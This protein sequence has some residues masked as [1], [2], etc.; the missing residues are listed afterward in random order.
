MG[1][2]WKTRDTKLGRE[3]AIKSLPEAFAS[4]SDRLARLERE[5]RMLATLN[6][7][8][9]AH[10]YG[11][12]ESDG[13][14]F[15]VMELVAGETLADRLRRG[16]IPVEEALKLGLQIAEALEAA[17]EKG[18][19]HRDLKPANIKVTPGGQVKVLDF[20]LAKAFIGNDSRNES[21]LDLSNSPT[22]SIAA[23]RQ[24]IILGTAAYMSPEQAKSRQLDKR[25][26]IWSFG[27]VLMEMLTGRATFSGDDVTDILAS[28]L[29]ADPDW[30][31]LPANLNPRLREV[32]DRCLEKDV[33]KRFRD[34]GDVRIDLQ[35]V[36]A[37]PTGSLAGALGKSPRSWVRTTILSAAVVVL[38]IVVTGFAAWRLKPPDP[39][40]VMNFIDVLPEDQ[41]QVIR[42]AQGLQNASIIDI[43]RDGSR[44]VYSTGTQIYIRN[45]NEMEP[46]P[47]QGASGNA[48]FAPI[49]SSD[50]QWL[51][52]ASVG[53]PISFKRIPVTGGTPATIVDGLKWPPF[54]VSSDVNE[55]LLFSQ[56]EGIMEVPSNGGKPRLVIPAAAGERLASP[57]RLPDGKSIL[58][59]V[60][61]NTGV[62]GWDSGQIQVYSPGTGS[63][64]TVWMAGNA[65]RYVPSGHI[66]FAQG[67]T[68]FA[69]PFDL[70][71]L[72]VTGGQVAMVEAVFR[73][74]LGNSDAT[75]YAISNTGSLVYFPGNPAVTDGNRALVWVDLKGKVTSIP[76]APLRAYT[77]ARISPDHRKVAL[78]INN[79][80]QNDIWT[81]DL[82]SHVL[83]QLTF[84][85]AN[86]MYPL[87]SRDG[88]RIFFYSAKKPSGVYSIPSQGGDAT[89]I[90]GSDTL[91]LFPASLHKD[92]RTI[93]VIVASG[94]TSIDVS[95]LT[96][97]GNGKFE[98]LLAED[99]IENEPDFAPNGNFMV[100]TENLDGRNSITVR[101]Y[102]D[103]HKYRIIVDNG[104]GP[105]FS[106]DGSEIFYFNGSGISAA[107]IEYGSGIRIMTGQ[108]LFAGSYWYGVAGPSGGQGRAWDPDP[109]GKRFLMI[110]IPAA[111]NAKPDL[112]GR[113][114]NIT[115]NWFQALKA[116]LP[117]P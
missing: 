94:A 7:P 77:M 70:S 33:N 95:T 5:A 55:M 80:N 45:L 101:P 13:T 50:G 35:K 84:D 46:R 79:G 67:G 27:C 69:V 40:P 115:L 85:A 106:G 25:T 110:K 41:A 12:E 86:E 61:T 116:K 83:T 39:H 37:D 11:L 36:L 81:F 43:A 18:V 64:T 6:H 47:V 112:I 92:A 114:I 87:W 58:F 102:P 60:T 15:L 76:E 66:V 31:S 62:T 88:S 44:L 96:L 42:A 57:Q 59:T 73:N 91:R 63:R 2:V 117:V 30:N 108:A 3:V 109:N 75:Q 54:S 24:G 32:L 65:A 21:P 90:A 29:R 113:Q 100:A 104:R 99:Y 17:H 68:L 4:D 19:I 111:S 26:D 22:E 38:A 107:A 97:G 8:N 52:Y 56:P 10:I 103:V 16:A 49:F 48:V 9:I 1:E 98:P 72:K 93:A 20:G 23:T 74:T 51:I 71:H 82:E 78:Q 14:R 34:I 28:V 105:V 53:P 89:F